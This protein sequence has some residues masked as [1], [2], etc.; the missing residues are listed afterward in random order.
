MLQINNRQLLVFGGL[1]RR[2][3]LND[4]WLFDY[5]E[6][7]WVELH[8]DG[9]MPA[10]RAHCTTTKF[11]DVVYLFGGYGGNGEVYGDLWSL[12][13]EGRVCIWQVG[14]TGAGASLLAAAAAAA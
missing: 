3:R 10:P 12:R 6:K 8:S 2:T 14:W 1:D 13:L 4:V 11:G 9:P 5:D 7:Q